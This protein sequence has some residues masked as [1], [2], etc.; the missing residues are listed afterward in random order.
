MPVKAEA[1]SRQGMFADVAAR[2]AA[3]RARIGE[4]A[5]GRSVRIVAVTKSFGADAVDAAVAAGLT[6]IGENYAQELVAKAASGAGG[7]AAEWHFIGAVQ[8]NKVARL[9]PFVA[10]WQTVDRPAVAEAIAR[11]SPGASALVQVNLSG[12]PQRAGCAWDDVGTV[13]GAARDAGLTVVGLMGVGPEGAPD[14][15]LFRRLAGMTAALGLAECSMGMS[16]D[17]E[18]AVAEGS[19]M[20]RLGSVLFGPR[21]ART[22]LRR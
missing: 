6:A 22:D 16:A 13:V 2:V 12:A 21:P 20:V 17:Y 5:G 15:A 1:S 9:A 14:P 18:V 3:V 11:H 7:G 19:T 10:V 8:R 4:L